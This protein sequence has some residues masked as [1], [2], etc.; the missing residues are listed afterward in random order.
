MKKENGLFEGI[1]VSEAM[2][3]CELVQV[4]SAKN[5]ITGRP[6]LCVGSATASEGLMAI[7]APKTEHC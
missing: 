3:Q 6:L 5:R 2:A 1:Y 4:S 7:N